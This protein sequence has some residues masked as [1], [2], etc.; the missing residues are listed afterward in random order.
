MGNVREEKLGIHFK[1]PCWGCGVNG[2]FMLM[3][4]WKSKVT[5]CELL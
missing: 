1:I 3:W 2:M 5:F 4:L